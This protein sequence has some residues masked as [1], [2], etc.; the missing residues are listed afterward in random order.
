MV[1]QLCEKLNMK[2]DEVYNMM[3]LDALNWLSM[4][5]MK[6]RYVQQLQKQQSEKIRSKY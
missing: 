2:P 5:A 4:F 3:Y 6:E 1:E